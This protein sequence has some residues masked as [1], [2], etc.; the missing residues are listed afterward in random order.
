MLFFL[1]G[2]KKEMI[3]MYQIRIFTLLCFQDFNFIKNYDS[4][5]FNLNLFF[6]KIIEFSE[7]YGK[8]RH[9]TLEIVHKSIV[10][11]EENSLDKNA[12]S[13]L[14]TIFPESQFSFATIF[15]FFLENEQKSYAIKIIRKEIE[16][17]QRFLGKNIEDIFNLYSTKVQISEKG[18]EIMNNYK[19]YDQLLSSQDHLKELE[20][21]LKSSN[22]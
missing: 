19:W 22:V 12:T 8:D 10:F 3:Y 18:L 7:L 14:Q 11:F 2:S 16:L 5:R 15:S 9:L 17:K 4:F 13:F 1:N 20:N 6:E 21:K